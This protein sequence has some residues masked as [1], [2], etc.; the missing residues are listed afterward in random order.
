M[1]AVY[2]PSKPK[3]FFALV[4]QPPPVTLPG[5]EPGVGSQASPVP[6]PS[7]SRWSALGTAAQLSSASSIP[8]LSLSG[9]QASPPS[10]TVSLSSSASQA[11]PSE[12]PSLSS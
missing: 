3:L 6:S 1:P 9:S 11:S 5:V 4:I 7:V 2:F 10:A 12:S 8:S